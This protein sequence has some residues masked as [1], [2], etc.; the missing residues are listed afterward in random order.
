MKLDFF[1]GW[2]AVMAFYLAGISPAGGA[3]VPQLIAIFFL[4]AFGLIVRASHPENSSREEQKILFWIL[5]V[6]CAFLSALTSA[7]YENFQL[8]AYS[9]LFTLTI[10]SAK[11]ISTK[12]DFHSLASLYLYAC[13]FLVLT[14]VI[15]DFD[16]IRVA[17]SATQT[18]K[19]LFRLRPFGNHP[20]LAAHFIGTAA[21]LLIA[22]M[23]RIDTK[24]NYFVIIPLLFLFLTI[25]LATSSRGSILALLVTSII[26]VV[27]TR[28][29]E[30][31]TPTVLARQHNLVL[32]IALLGIAALVIWKSDY[33]L[34]ILDINSASRGINSGGT[35]RFQNWAAFIEMIQDQP[36]VLFFGHGFRSWSDE[37]AF[38]SDNSYITLIY[39]IGLPL[40][41][42]V[43]VLLVRVLINSIRNFDSVTMS[44]EIIAVLIFALVE[45]IFARYLISIGNPASFIILAA[46]LAVQLPPHQIKPM[47][48]I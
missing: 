7:F 24:P 14:L 9:I 28:P 5:A 37:I 29:K 45:S 13:A 18:N 22:R 38:D 32:F 6:P 19:G 35:G 20:N 34:E 27:I 8:I 11:W 41:L 33:I 26:V 30:E 15:L 16:S 40:T 48:V 21:A 31:A 46:F 3:F 2:F 42:L 1:A 10:F 47:S 44:P 43:T 36:L 25:I 17:L 23:F 39:E 12:Y 4:V